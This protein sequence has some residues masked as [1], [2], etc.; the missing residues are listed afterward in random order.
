MR[1]WAEHDPKIA[2]GKFVGKRECGL[3]NIQLKQGKMPSRSLHGCSFKGH[4]FF[5]PANIGSIDCHEDSHYD[6]HGKQ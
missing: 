6:A 4:W 1:Y 3:S 5:S 2:K